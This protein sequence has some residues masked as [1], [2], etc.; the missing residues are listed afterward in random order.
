MQWVSWK[1]LLAVKL[2]LYQYMSYVYTIFFASLD[3]SLAAGV[4]TDSISCNLQM[5]A[6]H[7]LLA[8]MTR[9][10]TWVYMCP[11]KPSFSVNSLTRNLNDKFAQID[12]SRFSIPSQILSCFKRTLV[13]P[14]RAH[15]YEHLHS[16]V[17]QI[18][19]DEGRFLVSTV[20][21][22]RFAMCSGCLLTAHLACTPCLLHLC[23]VAR[24]ACYSHGQPCMLF[25]CSYAILSGKCRPGRWFSWQQR[26]WHCLAHL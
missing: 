23:S 20:G 8:C 1:L 26:L 18:R 5:R 10:A 21:L 14:S 4:L 6:I 9:S 2:L 17:S 7:A 24:L 16:V 12:I 19:Q 15:S 25:C 22:C 11:P 13:V 3:T